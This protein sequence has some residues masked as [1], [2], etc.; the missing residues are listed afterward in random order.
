MPCAEF[1]AIKEGIIVPL[2]PPSIPG[3]GTTGGFEFWIQ[4]EGD[5]GVARARRR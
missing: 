1:Q 5:G 4:S 3:L 2:N